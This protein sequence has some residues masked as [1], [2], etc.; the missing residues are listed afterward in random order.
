MV[1]QMEE[2]FNNDM[3]MQPDNFVEEE[4]AVVV[5]K[6]APKEEVRSSAPPKKNKQDKNAVAAETFKPKVDEIKLNKMED[7]HRGGDDDWDMDDN[8]SGKQDDGKKT[9][10]IDNYEDDWDMSDNDF[11]DNNDDLDTNKDPQS[12]YI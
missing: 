3:D 1:V 2:E 10:I 11:Q 12:A 8:S 7:L 6:K 5:N 4:V 9:E